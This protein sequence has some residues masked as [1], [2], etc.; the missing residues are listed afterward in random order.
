MTTAD[1]IDEVLE[2]LNDAGN[3]DNTSP[4]RHGM[5]MNVYPDR[6]GSGVS[7]SVGFYHTFDQPESDE[8][9]MQALN[10]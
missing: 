9:G 4:N 8:I 1:I 6:L 10:S 2:V 5:G 7:R 3:S